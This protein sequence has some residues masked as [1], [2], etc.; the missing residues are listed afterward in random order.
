[1]KMGVYI[2]IFLLVIPIQA[3]LLT[4]LSI[5]GIKPDLSLAL[6]YIIGLLVSPVEA[7]LIGMAGGLLLDIGSASLIGITGIT[8]GFVGVFASLLGRKVLDISSPSNGIFL[9]GF[10]MAEGICIAI[11]LQIVYGDFPFF[12]F[13]FFRI[14]PQTLYTG[15]LGV[16]LLRLS[17]AGKI[18]PVMKRGTAQRE[19]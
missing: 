18:L 10:S 7:A 3:S 15:I 17:A 2:I 14:L 9:A 11:I 12:D 5:A 19:F 6:L 1:M 13:L 16:L 8:R 4:P